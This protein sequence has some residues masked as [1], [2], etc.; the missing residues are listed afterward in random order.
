[1]DDAIKLSGW[2]KCELKDVHGR[3]KDAWEDHNLVVTAGKNFLA[4]WLA[5]ATQSTKF[6]PY[7]AIGSGS[8]SP[9]AIDTTL[10]T[11]L[12]RAAGTI[13]SAT[14]VYQNAASYAAGVGTGTIAEVGLFSA[15]SAGT[16]FARQTFTARPKDATDTLTVTWSIT[17][18]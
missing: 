9:Q 13:T 12:A 14:N 5:T 4:T 18:S 11:E 2:V 8:T 10:G 15:S 17:L 16:M 6:M 7:V 3:I 1:M